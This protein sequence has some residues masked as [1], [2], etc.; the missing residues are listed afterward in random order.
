[1]KDI[2]NEEDNEP[3]ISLCDEVTDKMKCN[4]VTDKNGTEMF[5]A[6]VARMINNKMSLTNTK[7]MDRT[8]R[9]QNIGR[10]TSRNSVGTTAIE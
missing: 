6:S 8:K 9:V 7:S 4:K 1:M 2:L 10:Y 3:P 5:K